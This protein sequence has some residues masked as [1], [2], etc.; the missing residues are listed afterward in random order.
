MY[1]A[2]WQMRFRPWLS[3]FTP[4]V[5]PESGIYRSSDGGR[6]W[7]RLQGHGWPAGPLGRIGLAATHTAQGTRV[8]AV[9]DAEKD[10]GLYA[11]RRRRRELAA[12]QRR[13]PS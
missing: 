5:G 8:Y 4:D 7:K 3:Y 10:G 12:R 2:A 1:A 11:L 6:S 13:Q 9:I